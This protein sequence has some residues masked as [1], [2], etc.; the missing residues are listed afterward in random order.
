MHSYNGNSCTI[1]HNSDI[2]GTLIIHQKSN[3]D[4]V[5]IDA[6]DILDFVA[7]YVKRQQISA[8]EQMDTNDILKI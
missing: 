2:S 6:S 4:S 8:L 1:H 5:S 7:D 3:G